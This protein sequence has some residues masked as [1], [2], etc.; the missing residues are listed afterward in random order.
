MTQEAL[1]QSRTYL[2]PFDIGNVRIDVP[3]TLAP[4]AGQTNH[5]FRTLCRDQGDCGLVCTELISSSLID[6]RKSRQKFDW[7][8]TESPL[9]VQLYGTNQ[10]DM[11]EAARI[12]QDHG[13]DI[14]DIN[15]GCWVP[16]VARKGGGAAL[17]KDIAVATRIVESVVEAVAIPVTV[18]VRSGWS[19]DEITAIDFAQQAERA[20]ALA[21]AV[22]ARTADQGFSGNAD[23]SIIKQVK[24]VVDIPVIG[25]G[26]VF[27][28]FDAQ[29]MFDDTGC[30]AIMVG[31]A[32]LGN[33]FIFS[34]VGHTLST[35]LPAPTPTRAELARVALQQAYR[36]LATSPLEDRHAVLELRGQISKYRLDQAG[37]REIRSRLV[38]CETIADIENVLLPIINS[39]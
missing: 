19:A 36:T 7:A 26:D 1:Q 15:M 11:V 24:D 39:V 29:R 35:G 10:T 4:M 21:V 32:S 18:K 22:H 20:G 23:W 13:A 33:P 25:N 28:G 12:L 38:R 27:D 30:D 2:K 17:L 34:Q 5:A 14:I 8:Q 6:S 16:K 9:A 3:L 37:Q 31:R